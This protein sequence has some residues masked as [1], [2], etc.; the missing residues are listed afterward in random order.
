MTVTV[1]KVSFKN[2]KPKVLNYSNYKHFI[3]ENYRN[4]LV[5]EFSKQNFQENSLE[6]FHEVC[7][8]VIDKHAP[9]NSESVRGNHSPFINRELSKAI[10]TRINS[11]KKNLKKTEGI[12]INTEITE[13]HLKKC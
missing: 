9:H 6:K 7:N 10:M 11:S 3:S 1:M 8:K 5:T 4:E 2:L 13:L 12:I